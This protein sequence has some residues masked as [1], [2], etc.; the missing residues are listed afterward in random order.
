MGICGPKSV[1]QAKI[2]RGG[3]IQYNLYI[4]LPAVTEAKSFVSIKIHKIFQRGANQNL[5]IPCFKL[6]SHKQMDRKAHCLDKN[7]KITKHD[8]S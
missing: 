3:P 8:I 1:T 7:R 5:I 6:S 4:L 2:T